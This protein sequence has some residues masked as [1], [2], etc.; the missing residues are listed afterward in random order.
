[1]SGRLGSSLRQRQLTQTDTTP[2]AA[3][4]S[5]TVTT[6][7]CSKSSNTA[8]AATT[9]SCQTS[10]SA[11]ASSHAERRIAPIAAG[12]EPSRKA[13]PGGSR[14]ARRIV[15]RRPKARRTRLACQCVRDGRCRS[16]PPAVDS[17]RMYRSIRSMSRSDGIAGLAGRAEG[18][19]GHVVR[20]RLCPVR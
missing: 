2:T 19:A 7:R 10:G 8:A 3:A 13:R 16:C 11:L 4:T 17:R 15:E 9:A 14:G 1:V 18:G 12:P 5:S 6:P 20:R